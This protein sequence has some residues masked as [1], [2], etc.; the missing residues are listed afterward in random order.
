MGSSVTEVDRDE[1]EGPRTR[2]TLTYGFW[3]G[4]TE[5]TQAQFEAMTG[6]NPSAFK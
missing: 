3:L 4:R 6:E 2:V 5:I 1:A